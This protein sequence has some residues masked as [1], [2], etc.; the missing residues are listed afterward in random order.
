VVRLLA[1]AVALALAVAVAPRVAAVALAGVSTEQLELLQRVRDNVGRDD[2]SLKKFAYTLERRSYDVNI[3]GKV[4][5]GEVKTYAVVPSPFEPGRSW[6]RLVAV[7][8]VRLTPEQLRREEQKARRD[9]EA[10]RRDRENETP[11]A[12]A[13]RLQREVQ[14]AQQ[15]RERLADI[16]R[17]FQFTAA[18]DEVIDGRP[19]AVFVMTPRSGAQT[20]SDAG[21]HLEKLR[22]RIWVDRAHAQLVRA[23]FETVGDITVGLGVIGR[24]SSGSRMVYRRDCAA[25]G[26]WLPIEMRFEGSGRTLMLIPFHLETWA[27]FA[28]FRP[29]SPTAT[30]GDTPPP[31]R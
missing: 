23:E 29:T 17:V 25:D 30:R 11:P 4:S 8:G 18:P 14:E 5:N 10:R 6:R 16:E 26:T 9:A 3:L 12:R 1:A 31:Q 13:R 28:D 22:G 24:V 21:R 2:D 20:R 27:K 7:N 19:L 15:E